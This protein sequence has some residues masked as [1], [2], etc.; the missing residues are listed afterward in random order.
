MFFLLVLIVVLFLLL[1][2]EEFSLLV[3]LRFF[4][5]FRRYLFMCLRIICVIVLVRSFSFDMLNFLFLV[6]LFIVC[7]NFLFVL[8]LF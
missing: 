3:V 8:G 5:F 1:Y 6:S 7:S 2:N 4:D